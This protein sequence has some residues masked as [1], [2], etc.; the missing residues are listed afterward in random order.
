MYKLFYGLLFFLHGCKG[1]ETKNENAGTAVFAV[2]N[3]LDTGSVFT[4]MNI[5]TEVRD[6]FD[7]DSLKK[8]T[9]NVNYCIQF[10]NWDT[11]TCSD[12]YNCSAIYFHSDTLNISIGIGDGFGAKGVLIKYKEGKYNIRPYFTTDAGPPFDLKESSLFEVVE[13]KLV[14]NKIYYK[15]GDSLFGRINFHL[16]EIVSGEKVEEHKGSGFFR[17]KIDTL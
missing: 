6:V 14:L 4:K 11:T 5:K 17:C 2:E 12:N 13:E 7:M 15:P 16:I 10:K 9:S 3:R 1:N 8:R